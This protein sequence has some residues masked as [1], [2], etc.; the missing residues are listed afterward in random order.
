MKTFASLLILPVFPFG[1]LAVPITPELQQIREIPEPI[2]AESLK[3]SGGQTGLEDGLYSPSV[4][5]SERAGRDVSALARGQAFLEA[6]EAQDEAVANISAPPLPGTN[7][8]V[9]VEITNRLEQEPGSPPPATSEAVTPGGSWELR[10]NPGLNGRGYLGTLD[11]SPL[12]IGVNG[13]EALTILSTPFSPS[14]IMG[15]DVN[16]VGEGNAGAVVSGGGD[17]YFPNRVLGD[18]GVVG[19]GLDNQAGGRFQ[20][21]SAPFCVVAGGRSNLAERRNST[22]GGGLANKALGVASVVAGGGYNTADGEFAS[23]LGGTS[24]LALSRFGVIAGGRTNRVEGRAG[25]IGAGEFNR[26]LG[27]QGVVGGGEYNVAEGPYAVVPGGSNNRAAGRFSLAAGRLA[28]ALHEGVF[29]WSDSTGRDSFASTAPHQFLIR[30]AGNVGIDTDRPSEKLSVAGNIAPD[31]ASTWTLGTPLLPWKSILVEGTVQFTEMLRFQ[32]PKGVVATLDADGRL[33]LSGGIE[34]KSIPQAPAPDPESSTPYAGQDLAASLGLAV[35]NAVERV[36]Q[37]AMEIRT[38][39][40]PVVELRTRVDEMGARLQSLTKSM[41]ALSPA[42]AVAPAPP[43]PVLARD[44]ALAEAVKRMTGEIASLGGRIDSQDTLVAETREWISPLRN[45][46]DA[47]VASLGEL[48][49]EVKRLAAVPDPAGEPSATPA[50]LEEIRNATRIALEELSKGLEA[51]MAAQAAV[52]KEM[53]ATVAS[54]RVDAAASPGAATGVVGAQG[55]EAGLMATVSGGAGNRAIGPSSVISGGFTNVAEEAFAVIGGGA[56]NRATGKY[57]TVAGGSANL[58]QG[59][60]GTVGGGRENQTLGAYSV[61][62]GGR[63]NLA[64]ADYAQAAGR[65]AKALHKGSFVWGDS[66]DED[67]ASERDDQFLIRASGGVSLAS[68]SALNSGVELPS[69]AS[70]WSV[71]C[72]ARLKHDFKPVDP[73]DS[74][75]R[76]VAMPIQEFALRSQARAVRHIGPVAEDYHAH[77]PYGEDERLIN[78]ADLDGIAL[79]AIQGLNRKLEEKDLELRRQREELEL[80]REEVRKLA[81]DRSPAHGR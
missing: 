23:I 48:E 16:H 78:T 59:T 51:R 21:L 38:G 20:Y 10:G 55:N 57:A 58:A 73:L 79:S 69:G 68:S 72:E 11:R 45:Q 28:S 4:R 70:A 1:A 26:V 36:E 46:V 17:N 75:A 71:R 8:N 35:S 44:A 64:K 42:P 24:N 15:S 63:D 9:R 41:D 47:A 65:R 5:T 74:L 2:R 34:S 32:G 25:F 31:R 29:V 12:R 66:T 67:F 53:I 30:A 50:Q 77:F 62:T 27:M 18:Y 3:R 19:G 33:T 61:I 54:N 49:A 43:A 40:S 56:Q 76:V 52:V 13:R 80:L 22:V 81:A 60:Y 6:M 14:I 37:L 7:D 39:L